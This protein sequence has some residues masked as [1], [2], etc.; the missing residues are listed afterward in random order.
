MCC[1]IQKNEVRTLPCFIQHSL[2][3]MNIFSLIDSC[4]RG[5]FNCHFKIFQSRKICFSHK[6]QQHQ[7][8]HIGPNGMVRLL[9][10]FCTD[11]PIFELLLFWRSS[12]QAPLSLIGAP[13]QDSA[14]HGPGSKHVV[15]RIPNKLLSPNFIVCLEKYQGNKESGILTKQHYIR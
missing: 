7:H 10:K 13:N 3:R 14:S 6:H 12:T 1:I 11:F 4:Y 9:D 2:C 8:I 5:I 15:Q